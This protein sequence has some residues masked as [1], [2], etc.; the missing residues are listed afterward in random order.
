MQQQIAVAL[1]NLEALSSEML[2]LADSRET[3]GDLESVPLDAQ[4]P[5]AG[6]CV[7]QQC[8]RAATVMAAAREVLTLV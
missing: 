7:A 6:Q 2:G 1:A 5:N 8:T 4:D 3:Q